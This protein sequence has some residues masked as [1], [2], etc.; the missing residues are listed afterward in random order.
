MIW[1]PSHAVCNGH[2]FVKWLLG[3]RVKEGNAALPRANESRDH[4][5]PMY[6]QGNPQVQKQSHLTLCKRGG[7]MAMRM[8]THHARQIE[9]NGPRMQG[10]H[11]T[12]DIT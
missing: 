1:V 8:R 2:G 12:L 5:R 10:Y 9:A 11:H 4:V 3:R 6:R 7:N